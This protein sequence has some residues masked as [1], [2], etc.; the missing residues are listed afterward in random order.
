MYINNDI[1]YLKFLNDKEVIIFGGGRLGQRAFMD[2][3]RE[4][5][6]IKITAFCDNDKSKQNIFLKGVKVIS[7]EELSKVNND[8]T[9]IVICCNAEKEVKEQLL[10]KKIYNFIS[11]SQIDFG[12]GEEYYDSQY[13]EW[14]QSMGAF[15][16]KISAHMFQPYI[17]EDAI[18]IE[19]GSGGG[20]LLNC[21][22]AK[23]KVGVEIN[24][25][26]RENAQKI[27]IRSVKWI[28]ELPDNYADV[29]ISAHALEHVENPLGILRDLHRKLKDHGKIVFYVPNE[30]CDTEYSR[31]EINNHLYTWNCLTIG[32]L[33]KAAGY[34]VRSVSK[35]QEVW[36]D[37]Y[38]E[39]AQEVSPELFEALCNIGGKAFDKNNCLIVAD[40]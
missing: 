19:F 37:N 9:M 31:S 36:P 29:I 4:V 25:V 11:I 26:A 33:F 24:D 30:S 39:I 14:Q 34:F 7:V 13:F 2:L 28:S 12:G 16:G 1:D 18:V 3:S 22:V 15:G 6:N 17:K 21:I 35:I 5:E 10:S 27:G 38:S 32:N 8:H 20:Y 40:K 23:E